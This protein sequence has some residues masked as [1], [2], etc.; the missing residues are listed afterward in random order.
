MT[1]ELEYVLEH[2]VPEMGLRFIQGEFV[3]DA[4]QLQKQYGDPYDKLH[5]I[6]GPIAKERNLQI[7]CVEEHDG[8]DRHVDFGD[9]RVTRIEVIP[10]DRFHVYWAPKPKENDPDG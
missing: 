8:P 7:W 3:L 10:P 1:T 2:I 6:F 9:K 4:Q 5:E